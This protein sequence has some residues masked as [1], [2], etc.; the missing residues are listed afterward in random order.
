M[1]KKRK[2][3]FCL[4]LYVFLFSHQDTCERHS[5]VDVEIVCYMCCGGDFL[6]DGGSL[7]RWNGPMPVIVRDENNKIFY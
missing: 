6:A 7:T 3:Y 1:F 4:Q 5:D 2:D